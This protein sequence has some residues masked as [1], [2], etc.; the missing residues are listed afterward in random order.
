M[1]SA[2][3]TCTTTVACYGKVR[4]R[5]KDVMTLML[6]IDN[7]HILYHR[8]VPSPSQQGTLVLCP[9]SGLPL[10]PVCACLLRHLEQH[11]YC[12][13]SLF[14]AEFQSF[15]S[16]MRAEHPFPAQVP[17]WYLISVSMCQHQPFLNTILWDAWTFLSVNNLFFGMM[18][19]VY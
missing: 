8:D 14:M 10:F 19:P 9:P 5:R 1:S 7:A 16:H 18:L 13:T 11:C 15:L 12:Y 2:I 4:E 6:V 3:V 17:A